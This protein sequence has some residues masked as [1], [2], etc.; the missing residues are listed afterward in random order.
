MDRNSDQPTDIQHEDDAEHQLKRTADDWRSGMDGT[1][2]EDAADK[3]AEGADRAAEQP[4]YGRE[5]S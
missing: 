3:V 1:D 2:A 4:D 5:G